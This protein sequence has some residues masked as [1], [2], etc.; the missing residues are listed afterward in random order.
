LDT[1]PH[2]LYIDAETYHSMEVSLQRMTLRT[3]FETLRQMPN[4]GMLGIG[5]AID[6]EPVEFFHG[7]PPQEW[8]EFVCWVAQ[9][10]DWTIC[11][12]NAAFDVRVLRFLLGVPQ[13]K[14]VHCSLE[15]AYGAFANQPGGYALKELSIY[16]GL[17]EKLAINLKEGEHTAEELETYC[18]QDVV[19]CRA[20]HKVELPRLTYDHAF[21]VR[22]RCWAAVDEA[23]DA[24]IQ[25]QEMAQKVRE[26]C[27]HIDGRAVAE[28]IIAFN[29]VSG[30]E[31]AAAA[32]AL[33]VPLT[34]DVRNKADEKAAAFGLTEDLRLKS[35]KPRQLKAALLDI[36]GFDTQSI[37]VKKINPARLAEN[38]RASKVIH[39]AARANKA[40]SHRRKMAVFSGVPIVDV[41]LSYH[42]AHTGRYSSK[43]AAG[44]AG[45]SPK[46]VNL[47]NL[48]KRNKKVAEPIRKIFRTD[49]DHCWVSTDLA[50]AEYRMEGWLTNSKYVR[51]LYTRDLLIDPYSEFG[52]SVTGKPVNKSMPVRQVWKNS[53][54]GLGFDMGIQ[55]WI[56]EL[57]LM[58]A[59]FDVNKVK[60]E[61]LRDLCHD[62]H[63][64]P[65]T[66]GRARAAQTKLGAPWEVA[67]V[68][69]HSR[70]L[71]HEI[72]PEFHS[73]ACWVMDTLK[74]V[75]SALDPAAAIEQAYL[76]PAAPLRDRIN[77]VYDPT[78]GPGRTV[79]VCCGGWT[80][81]VT[82]RDIGVHDTKFGPC[83]SCLASG[84]KGY[85]S[86]NPSV[87]I[88]NITQSAA[89]NALVKG[90]LRLHHM[91]YDWVMSV[92]DEAKLW[93]PRTCDAVLNAADA[94]MQVYG[95]GNELGWGWAVCSN[96]KEVTVTES[97]WEKE[98]DE[99]FWHA[100]ATGDASVLA[101][102]V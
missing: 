17:G 93:V 66:D 42:A 32:E 27:L 39:S 67:T 58:L 23:D 13:P 47:H 55:R 14:H 36:C 38:E 85:R 65:T 73:T 1:V 26:L 12:H 94:L 82:W 18:K 92:H 22:N 75:S 76:L 86:L 25:I 34:Y 72:H 87:V 46:G 56:H 95:P 97:L 35:V 10:D 54:L 100:L 69:Y 2:V 80:P 89:R 68:A 37:S 6:D 84:D 64:S 3:Y 74:A 83:F 101:N 70:R 41:E 43:M 44:T 90:K 78:L 50:N 20:N 19:L 99:T 21:K 11:A 79:R 77:L 48:P 45:H 29:K 59:D 71:F 60:L 98:L 57:L 28:A 7:T 9:Q 49:R 33:G 40:L 4:R 15:L 51:E 8:I 96:P 88:E 61:D 81:T 63:W 52:F 53:V 16:H 30:E 5:Y 102:L 91:G 24:E 62:N 31:A